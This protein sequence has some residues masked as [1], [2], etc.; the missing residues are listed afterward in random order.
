[1]VD[2]AASPSGRL[3]VLRAEWIARVVRSFPEFPVVRRVEKIVSP[4]GIAACPRDD[5]L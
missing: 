4:A 1:M 2:I 3:T 5:R